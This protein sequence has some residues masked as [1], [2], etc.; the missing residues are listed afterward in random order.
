MKLRRKNGFTLIELLVVIAILGTVA[1]VAVP[2]VLK[3]IGTGN[4][5]AAKQEL[6]NVAAATAAALASE[7]PVDPTIDDAQIIAGVGVGKFMVQNTEFKYTI[8]SAGNITQG[9]RVS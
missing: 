5:A 9:G 2:N 4:D 6:L 7:P 8:D 3:F 1:A